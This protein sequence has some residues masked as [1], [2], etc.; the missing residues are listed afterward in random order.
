MQTEE[1]EDR[2]S[3]L[4]QAGCEV[5]VFWRIRRK[6]AAMYRSSSLDN[7]ELMAVYG[8]ERDH[9]YV[10]DEDCTSEVRL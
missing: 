2:S 1:T 3:A 6:M 8:G 4:L 10:R 7:K 5:S 9:Y